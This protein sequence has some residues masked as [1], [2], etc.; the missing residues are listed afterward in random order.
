M[1][2]VRGSLLLGMAVVAAVGIAALVPLTLLL[3]GGVLA[4]AAVAVRTRV[5]VT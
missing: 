4:L 5:E 2:D 1:G 3:L